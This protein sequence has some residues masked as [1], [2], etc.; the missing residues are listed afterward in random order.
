[1]GNG[2]D[3]DGKRKKCR[4]ERVGP[5]AANPNNLESKKERKQRG[6]HKVLRAQV[7]IVQV[8]KVRPLCL[9]RGFRNISIVDPPLGGPMRV[10]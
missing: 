8:E 1:M 4:K 9:I 10:A 5:V 7:R 6:E 2:G 3:L